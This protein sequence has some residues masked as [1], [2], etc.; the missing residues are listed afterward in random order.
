MCVCVCVNI[1]S[2][3]VVTPRDRTGDHTPILLATA[4]IAFNFIKVYYILGYVCFTLFDLMNI[5][6]L[7]NKIIK[8]K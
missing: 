1:I 8:N 7:Q 6:Y 4:G 2:T 3:P 5:I